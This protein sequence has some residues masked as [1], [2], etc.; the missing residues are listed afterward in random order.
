LSNDGLPYVILPTTV[1]LKSIRLTDGL[2]TMA[3]RP[4]A[5]HRMSVRLLLPTGLGLGRGAEHALG[6]V[7][8]S[9]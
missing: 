5:V 6:V 9:G 7:I 2:P 8:G 1:C 4:M 3:I